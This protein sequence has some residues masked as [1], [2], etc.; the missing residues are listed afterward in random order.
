MEEKELTSA[1]INKQIRATIFPLLR[2]R[3]F[4]KIGTTYS[5]SHPNKDIVHRLHIERFSNYRR[6]VMEYPKFTMAA[7]IFTYYPEDLLNPADDMIL[8]HAKRLREYLNSSGQ[9]QISRNLAI[10]GFRNELV[11]SI[12]Q[13]KEIPKNN[14]Q[15]RY[16]C[17]WLM[18][19]QTPEYSQNIINDI[20]QQFIE[21][22]DKYHEPL[23]DLKETLQALIDNH[24]DKYNVY[25]GPK[26][27]PDNRGGMR[28]R[29]KD[30]LKRIR[31]RS[32]ESVA[33]SLG[34]KKLA[35]EYF[36]KQYTQT[37]VM[38]EKRRRKEGRTGPMNLP[39]KRQAFVDK[40]I[41]VI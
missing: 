37:I 12:D 18:L 38:Q 26:Y 39:E 1:I 21:N 27:E 34:K 35:R 11:K 24:D 9:L 4:E 16:A 25:Y 17:Q 32:I 41:D 23:N 31:F 19:Q 28:M 29:D 6:S 36:E 8:D 2:E 15:H 13:S 33:Q 3:G 22:F 5:F 7:T 10:S 40:W 14:R 20:A 30:S